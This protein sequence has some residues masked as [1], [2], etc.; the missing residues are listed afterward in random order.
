MTH[1]VSEACLNECYVISITI[2]K[3]RNHCYN[4]K[5]LLQETCRIKEYVGLRNMWNHRCLFKFK[6]M[7]FHCALSCTYNEV[8]KI[9]KLGKLLEKIWEYLTSHHLDNNHVHENSSNFTIKIIDTSHLVRKLIDKKN[10]N[11]F[12][13]F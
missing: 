12:F 13:E 7:F 9:I 8:C 6:E 11:F 5:T 10:I 1:F 3:D 2:Y 4:L